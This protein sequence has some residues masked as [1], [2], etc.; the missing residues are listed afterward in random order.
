[1]EL[2]LDNEGV[3]DKSGYCWQVQAIGPENLQG[4]P[5]DTS[6]YV[7]A[8]DK[9]VITSPLDGASDVEYNPTTFTWN[10][11]WAPGGYMI[12]LGVVSST[13]SNCSWVNVSGKSYTLD[14]KPGTNYFWTVDAKG[15]NG[16]LTHPG[17]PCISRPKQ[18]PAMRPTSRR[19]STHPA[20]RMRRS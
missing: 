14:L 10:S 1:M 18:R 9:P 17:S 6:C 15:L 7:L 19:T 4:P 2:K 20:T 11:E 13:G 3:T 5:S 16:E 8:P 12:C